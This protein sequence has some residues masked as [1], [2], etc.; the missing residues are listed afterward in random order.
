M[1][2]FKDINID[3]LAYKKWALLCSALFIAAG[4]ISLVVRGPRFGVDFAGGTIVQVKFQQTAD[5]AKIRQALQEIQLGDSTIQQYGPK[6]ENEVLI[7]MQKSTGS[8]EGIGESI[9]KALVNH[10]TEQ[11][12]E[13]RR[14]EMVGPK[15]GKDL[16]QQGL[17]AIIFSLIGILVYAWWRFDFSFSVGG[18]LALAHD[19][20]ITIGAISLTNREFNLTVLAAVL[21]IIGYSINDT[22][23][24]YDRV[25]EN[26]RLKRGDNLASI[27]NVSINETMG[28][29]F[30]TSFTTFLVCLS[31]FL[32][33]GQVINDFAFAMVIGVIAGSYSTVFIASPVALFIHDMGKGKAQRSPSAAEGAGGSRM[34]AQAAKATTSKIAAMNKAQKSTKK[35][36]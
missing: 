33:G 17:W 14:V 21:T 25:R 32:L 28:R 22:I 35:V 34:T 30:L 2:F 3:F 6:S 31:L 12:F 27:I 8:L 11:G 20:L 23:V 7:S 9:R 1:R 5:L 26:V 15:V 36:P 4:I 16:R 19:T 10:F 18:I 24:I 13:I 29:T